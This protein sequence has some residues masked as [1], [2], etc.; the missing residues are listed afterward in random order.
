MPSPLRFSISSNN[1]FWISIAN[2]YNSLDWTSSL[3]IFVLM[4]KNNSMDPIKPTTS[5]MTE[6]IS[7]IINC[8]K[9]GDIPMP[10]TDPRADKKMTGMRYHLMREDNRKYVFLCSFDKT[11]EL[12]RILSR[13][14]LTSPVQLLTNMTPVIGG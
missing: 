9:Y 6:H 14:S 1:V 5:D 3:S 11:M 4:A 2:K 8:G 13:M 7:L 10:N 12:M